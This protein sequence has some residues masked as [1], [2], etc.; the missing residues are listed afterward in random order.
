M[1]RDTCNLTVSQPT[2]QRISQHPDLTDA[3][4]AHLAGI[5]PEELPR[6]VRHSLAVLLEGILCQR[7]PGYRCQHTRKDDR[8]DREG[9]A[10]AASL[11]VPEHGFTPAEIAKGREWL[12]NLQRPLPAL[13]AFYFRLREKCRAHQLAWAK[14]AL[15]ERLGLE[16]I[17]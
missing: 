9:Y 17:H 12:A 7:V 11:L 15:I 3:E 10:L 4:R 16:R 2:A 14:Q 5:D 13:L 6:L 8:A 1:W